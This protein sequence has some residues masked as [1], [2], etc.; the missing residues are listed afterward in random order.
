[1][2]ALTFAVADHDESAVTAALKAV[3][4][5]LSDVSASDHDALI[6]A[7]IL[8]ASSPRFNSSSN[9]DPS[10]GLNPPP[11]PCFRPLE[12]TRLVCVTSNAH[13]LRERTLDALARVGCWIQH[14]DAWHVVAETYVNYEATTFAVNMFTAAEQGQLVVEWNKLEGCTLAF[15]DT[16]RAFALHCIHAAAA[17][18]TG[19][20]VR[21]ESRLSAMDKSYAE[22]Q[23][24][25]PLV[26]PMDKAECEETMAPVKAMLDSEWSSSQRQGCCTVANLT[27]TTTGGASANTRQLLAYGVVPLLVKHLASKDRHTVRCAAAAIANLAAS[28]SELLPP[29]H[30]NFKAQFADALPHIERACRNAQDRPTEDEC[31]RARTQIMR[32]LK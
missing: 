20:A 28:T 15:C 21:D 1:M 6:A 29:D 12:P 30:V 27:S 22:Q 16:Y 5:G 24:L 10:S 32:M 9:S 23:R 7:T 31:Q 8:G 14:Q 4:S 13:E 18:S 25:P 19:A 11:S 17:A 2:N 26:L 3:R